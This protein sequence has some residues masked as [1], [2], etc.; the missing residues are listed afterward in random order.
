MS[1]L[2]GITILSGIL[3]LSLLMNFALVILL[4][5]LYEHYNKEKK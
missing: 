1:T 2:C 3:I 4:K 5:D